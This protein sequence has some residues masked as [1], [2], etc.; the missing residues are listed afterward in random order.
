MSK[1]QSG[2]SQAARKIL[3]RIR[4]Y[5]K[6]RSRITFKRRLVGNKHLYTK[7]FVAKRPSKWKRT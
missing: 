6:Q 7:G 5:K 2:L 3:E 1:R 4:V